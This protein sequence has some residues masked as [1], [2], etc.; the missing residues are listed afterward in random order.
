MVLT[1]NQQPKFPEFSIS[2]GNFLDWQKQN[3]VF[4]K[5]AAINGSAFI[6][7]GEGAEP[8]RLRGA[9]VSA[10]LFEMLGVNPVHGRTFLEEEDQPGHENVVILSNGLW[11]RRFAADP[12]VISQPITLSGIS[13]TIIGIMPASFGFPD[14]ETDVWAPVAFTARDAQ[15]HGGHYLSAIGRLKARRDRRASAN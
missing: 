4:E 8:E 2:P 6:L 12:N 5:L 3:T 15:A 10:G 9:R 1:E 14:R 11:K 7:A 13:Y